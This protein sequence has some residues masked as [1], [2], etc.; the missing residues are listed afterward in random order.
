MRTS[1]P[2]RGMSEG[3]YVVIFCAVVFLVLGVIVG[4]AHWAAPPDHADL[5]KGL[6]ERNGIDVK[7]VELNGEPG[8]IQVGMIKTEQGETLPIVVHYGS[9]R[10]VIQ[11]KTTFTTQWILGKKPDVAHEEIRKLVAD[12]GLEAAGVNVQR[13]PNGVGYIG[14]VTARSG[15]IIDITEVLGG[16]PLTTKQV[17]QLSP[18]SY[19]RWIRNTLEKELKEELADVSEFVKKDKTWAMEE[20]ERQ[21]RMREELEQ[22][23]AKER[24]RRKAAYDA[25]L[26]DIR[27]SGGQPTLGE[28]GIAQSILG[29]DQMAFDLKAL[30][31]QDPKDFFRQR[32]TG[33]KPGPQAVVTYQSATATTKGGQVFEL[34][35]QVQT[36]PA[37]SIHLSWREKKN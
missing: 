16:P 6:K 24:A 13:N 29:P 11:G 27:R 23:Q 32:G 30:L 25:Y 36:S 4:I 26:A 28:I 20:A 9:R 33:E 22:K 14:E 7:T 21:D 19:D 15:E 3:W 5:R 2:R 31:K 1:L 18:N 17:A 34:E 12:M 37:R 35:T 10:D 8:G